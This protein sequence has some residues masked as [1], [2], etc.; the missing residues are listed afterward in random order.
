MFRKTMVIVV[1]IVISVFYLNG[2]KKRADQ[3][4]SDTE[5]V[6]TAAEY[7]GKENNQLEARRKELCQ[8]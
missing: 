6:K 3:T 2:C 4:Q 5:K 1:M 8:G 7:M